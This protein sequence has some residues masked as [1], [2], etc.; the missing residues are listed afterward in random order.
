[1]NDKHTPTP[2]PWTVAPGVAD[3]RIGI[4]AD[5]GY[6]VASVH[7]FNGAPQ[8]AANAR[9]ICAAPR[10]LRTLTVIAD[11]LDTLD[12]LDNIKRLARAAIEQATGEH[13]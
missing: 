10:M 5:D 7:N 6:R 11:A 1:M 2:G 3:D 13:A 4:Y 8:N 12:G 9:L